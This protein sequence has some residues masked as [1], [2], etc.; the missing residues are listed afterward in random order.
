VILAMSFASGRRHA[1][2]PTP[3]LPPPCDSFLFQIAAFSFLESE[4]QIIGN[5]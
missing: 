4:S 1:D 3:P 2:T 5:S